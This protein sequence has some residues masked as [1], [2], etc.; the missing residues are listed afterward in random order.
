MGDTEGSEEGTRL[1][2]EVGVLE[3]EYDG[4]DVGDTEGSKEGAR[5]GEE[6]G[7]LEGE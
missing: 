1:G 4:R 5:L 2:E 3:G 6:V 7:V